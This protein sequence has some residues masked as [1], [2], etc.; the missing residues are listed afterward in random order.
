MHYYSPLIFK[1]ADEDKY[2]GGYDWITN[3]DFDKDGIY[4]NN[5]KS[6]ESGLKD[7]IKGSGNTHWVIRPTL[8]TS[9]IEFME[10]DRKNLVL[11]YHIYHAKDWKNIHDWERIEIRLNNIKSD[12]DPAKVNVNGFDGI[13]FH[14]IF[15]DQADS[16]AVTY[17]DAQ[18]IS[19]S[20]AASLAT[21]SAARASS[22]PLLAYR[23]PSCPRNGKYPGFPISPLSPG[24]I[25]AVFA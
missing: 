23:T 2:G 18:R 9:L 7:Y 14:Y 13:N 20:K 19:S 16:T 15:S 8:H 6:W 17:F 24:L 10:N 5:K 4:Y 11:F 22:S 3:F 12:S 25:A 1:C 21:A